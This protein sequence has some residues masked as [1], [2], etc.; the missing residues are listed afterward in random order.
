[1]NPATEALSQYFGGMKRAN[2][3]AVQDA[4]QFT[5]WPALA[6]QVLEE[7]RLQL[8]R[9]LPKEDLVAIASGDIDVRAA[10]QAALHAN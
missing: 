4:A 1:M 2:A 6:A 3:A 7:E 9:R 5:D 8:L 10:A